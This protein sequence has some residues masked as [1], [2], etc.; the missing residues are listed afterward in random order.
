ML[1]LSRKHR[2]SVVVG[3]P[4]VPIEMALKVTVLEINKASVRL[5]F[6]T[7]A[8][9]PVNRWEVWQRIHNPLPS[10]PPES[11]RAVN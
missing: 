1:I 9:I 4:A 10:A 3:D 11:L 2:Q 5:G 6:E 8:S 7:A